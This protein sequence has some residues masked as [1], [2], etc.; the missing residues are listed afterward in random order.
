MNVDAIEKMGETIAGKDYFE[1]KPA[2]IGGNI[3]IY[4]SRFLAGLVNAVQ[5]RKIV[6]IGVA[7]GWSSSILLKTLKGNGNPFQLIGLDL[8]PEYYL[9]KSKA[10][11]SAVG[12]MEGDVRDCYELLTGGI[13]LDL[14]DGIG[15]VDF[16]FIDAN[17]LHPWTTFDLIAVL[18]H[19]APSS[20]VAMHDLSLCMFERHAHRNRGPFYLYNFWPDRKFHSTQKPPMIG[21][22]HVS[23]DFTAYADIL[24]ETLATP[25]ETPI[26]DSVITSLLNFVGRHF[27]DETSERFAKVCYAQMK[28]I[29]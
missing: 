23:S 2:W 5:P 3:S 6:E 17:H 11:G 27:G 26:S 10:T 15:S 21:A 16:A 13:A 24:C 4:D 19:L 7:S 8:F 29:A 22:V 18:P 25:W 20:W 1:R 9:D 28:R 14:M 12:E